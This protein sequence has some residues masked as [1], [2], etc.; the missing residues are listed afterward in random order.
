MYS[1]WNSERFIQFLLHLFFTLMFPTTSYVALRISAV[2]STALLMIS[3]L[4]RVSAFKNPFFFQ[5][6]SLDYQSQIDRRRDL[7][8]TAEVNLRTTVVQLETKLER[9]RDTVNSQ[10]GVKSALNSV[11][12][13]RCVEL[14]GVTCTVRG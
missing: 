11:Y 4:V 3:L 13:S 1:Y 9:S 12:N 8:E 7:L 14:P 10:V 2:Q 5:Q 6:Q